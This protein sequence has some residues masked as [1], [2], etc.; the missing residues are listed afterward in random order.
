MSPNNG[1][2]PSPDPSA[3]PETVLS[4]VGWRE[5]AQAV[6]GL[7]IAIA[8][9]FYGLPFIADTT[10]PLIGEQ[11]ALVGAGPA[12]AMAGLLVTGLYC[13]T[14]TMIGSLPGLTHL[15]AFTVNT[16][17]SMVANVLPGGGAIGV[18]VTYLMYRSWGFARAAIGTSL[19]VT[20]IWNM[21]ARLTLPIMGGLAVLFGPVQAPRS[22]VVAALVA[23]AIGLLFLGFF[24]GVVF[25]DMVARE[26]GAAVTTLISPLAR[27]FPRVRSLD[28]VMADQRERIE[29][30]VRR[31][32]VV[33]TL[34]LA[35]MFGCFFVLYVVSA[36]T[37][38]VE[39]A[40]IPLFAAYAFRQFLTVVAI[41][42]GGLGITEVGTAGILVAFGGDPASA[43]AAALLYAVFT[44]LLE[45]PLG[46]LA[47]LGWWLTRK[48][49]VRAP[50]R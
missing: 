40:L 7:G 31:S 43:A 45:V 50:T 47:T 4:A 1:S 32:S 23:T 26:V 33:M 41:T 16:A 5:V 25:S 11:L 21:L 38:G 36:R 34:G 9:V 24:S 48:K 6:V 14:F 20:T 10:W 49:S 27:R 8:V 37:V 3:E 39:L 46:A 19:V 13:Y 44:H 29:G 2:G 30:V 35:G 42:P 22:V 28:G 15:R 17:G 12:L 18:A